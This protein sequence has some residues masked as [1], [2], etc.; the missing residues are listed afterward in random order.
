MK[1]FIISEH[2]VKF[3]TSVMESERTELAAGEQTKAETHYHQWII[4]NRFTKTKKKKKKKNDFMYM[5]DIKTFAK[6]KRNN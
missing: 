2:I 3:I 6:N 1:M 5:N 4:Y